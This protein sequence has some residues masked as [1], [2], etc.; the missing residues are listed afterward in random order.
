[1]G[2]ANNQ[3]IKVELSRQ[4]SDKSYLGVDVTGTISAFPSSSSSSTIASH[5]RGVSVGR[6]GGPRLSQ[7]KLSFKRGQAAALNKDIADTLVWTIAHESLPHPLCTV[8]AKRSATYST[9]RAL[10]SEQNPEIKTTHDSTFTFLIPHPELLWESTKELDINEENTRTIVCPRDISTITIRVYYNLKIMLLHGTIPITTLRIRNETTLAN[11]RK[12]LIENAFYLSIPIRFDFLH[13]KQHVQSSLRSSSVGEVDSIDGRY[14]LGDGKGT[15]DFINDDLRSSCGTS[16]GFSISERGGGD[17]RL[18]KL[19]RTESSSSDKSM[20][21]SD[22]FFQPLPDFKAKRSLSFVPTTLQSRMSWTRRTHEILEEESSSQRS[23]GEDNKGAA[24]HESSATFKDEKKTGYMHR[25]SSHGASLF[26]A[27]LR[28]DASDY[29]VQPTLSTSSSTPIGL[30]SSY[31]NRY[32]GERVATSGISSSSSMENKDKEFDC[33]PVTEEEES[34]SLAFHYF[35]RIY[36][37]PRGHNHSNSMDKV[38]GVGKAPDVVDTI[39]AE[40]LNENSQLVCRFVPNRVLKWMSEELSRSPTSDGKDVPRYYSSTFNGVLMFPDVS[41]FTPLTA[42]LSKEGRI[43]TEKLWIILNSY[44]DNMIEIVRSFGGDIIKFCGDALQVVFDANNEKDQ[45]LKNAAYRAVACSIRLRDALHGYIISGIATDP[46][47]LK[48][49]VA[50]GCGLIYEL[51]AGGCYNRYEFCISGET[52]TQVTLVEHEANPGDVVVS[53]EGWLLIKSLQSLGILSG[54]ELPN[55]K[56]FCIEALANA[57]TVFS[58]YTNPILKNYDH[59]LLA[60]KSRSYVN[61][62]FINR[63]IVENRSKDQRLDSSEMRKVSVLFVNLIGLES[64]DSKSFDSMQAALLTIQKLLYTLEGTLR[65][66]LVDDKGCVCIAVFGLYPLNHEDDP[67]RATVTALKLSEEI[68]RMGLHC[69]IGVATGSAF[70]GALGNAWRSEYVVIGDCV[71]LSARLMGKAGQSVWCDESTYSYSKRVVK[72]E[73]LPPVQ[74]KG[75]EGLI[76][77]YKPVKLLSKESIS[78]D[79]HVTISKI[80]GREVELDFLLKKISGLEKNSS[81]KA[82]VVLH[83]EPGMGKTILITACK[84]FAKEIGVKFIVATGNPYESNTPYFAIKQLYSRVQRLR[85]EVL[86]IP[87]I[88]EDEVKTLLPGELCK[89]SGLMHDIMGFIPKDIVPDLDANNRKEIIKKMIFALTPSI[90]R[91]LEPLLVIIEDAQFLDNSSW[92][93]LSSIIRKQSQDK[94]MFLFSLR[95][96][97]NTPKPLFR[98]LNLS[99]TE[100]LSLSSLDEKESAALSAAVLGVTVE[101]LPPSLLIFLQKQAQGHP[102]FITQTLVSLRD[103][104]YLKV[105]SVTTCE[106]LVEDLFSV[107]I[108]VSVEGLV[109]A[110]L[111]KLPDGKLNLL[112]IASII[113]TT[114]DIKTLTHLLEVTGSDSLL[115][116]VH[117][118]LEELVKGGYLNVNLTANS[119][120]VDGAVYTFKNSMIQKGIYGLQLAGQRENVHRLIAQYMENHT[121]SHQF[122]LLSHHWYEARNV[123]KAVLYSVKGATVAFEA[124]HHMEAIEMLRKAGELLEKSPTKQSLPRDYFMNKINFR[125]LI[126]ECYFETGNQRQLLLEAEETLRLC[127]RPL[128]SGSETNTRWGFLKL[129]L[130]TRFYPRCCRGRGA[131]EYE[132]SIDTT[133]FNILQRVSTVYYYY[134]NPYHVGICALHM[135]DIA[136]ATNKPRLL[137]SSYAILSFALMYLGFRDR[138]ARELHRADSHLAAIKAK[139]SRSSG[140][141]EVKLQKSEMEMRLAELSVLFFRANFQMCSGEWEQAMQNYDAAISVSLL[142]SGERFTEEMVM[143]NLLIGMISLEIDLKLVMLVLDDLLETARERLDTHIA[144]KAL[145]M[146]SLI[147][148]MQSNHEDALCRFKQATGYIQNE[149]E[150]VSNLETICLNA[151]LSVFHSPDDALARIGECIAALSSTFFFTVDAMPYLLELFKSVKTLWDMY[152]EGSKEDASKIVRHAVFL[153]STAKTLCSHYQVCEALFLVFSAVT[154]RMQGELNVSLLTAFQR[155]CTVARRSNLPHI[156]AYSHECIV[157]LSLPSA[158]E[159]DVIGAVESA[160]A[161]YKRIDNHHKMASL[162]FSLKA[163]PSQRVINYRESIAVS[164]ISETDLSLTSVRERNI[165]DSSS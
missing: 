101:V 124:K 74:L 123:D 143:S 136:G 31:S 89:Y 25:T 54:K 79:F 155:A 81:M 133:V 62:S 50:I 42:L 98:I 39:S 104:G 140:Q 67:Q 73:I 91:K 151:T 122:E 94:A 80:V 75:K 69:G 121:S 129:Y 9:I 26:P 152:R 116:T 126:V 110:S 93:L 82:T 105:T 113:G 163:I 139:H 68:S 49:K 92:D 40:K 157:E 120:P 146:Q 107:G 23:T 85:S 55:S 51:S 48:L 131:D 45:L 119:S 142:L 19:S 135:Y 115:P 117:T 28:A 22:Q 35:P 7:Q 111:D 64:V 72:F 1:M 59:A 5:R 17:A 134:G 27:A 18:G 138:A 34:T 66:F 30:Y 165:S 43:G 61:A 153:T 162:S 90:L 114:F 160:L 29:Y 46:V 96:M 108:P 100:Q 86:H 4:E 137:A 33:F 103:Q 47:V 161:L 158:H 21:F 70:A 144:S 102:F 52:L 11:I 99:T 84:G 154:R 36:I 76:N 130:K 112:K 164:S 148:C 127:N 132:I 109:A 65:Q 145:R 20:S 2:N 8:Q 63:L 87:L 12:Q 58:L 10:I 106:V 141:S 150:A 77:V 16:D 71:N 56:G 37:A 159:G 88:D 147:F 57:E 44:F 125:A 78:S 41:G 95:P 32:I 97:R 83:G 24:V 14:S 15:L 38:T 118:T 156:E 6:D 53:N 3:G 60:L 13:Q 128:V 149:C